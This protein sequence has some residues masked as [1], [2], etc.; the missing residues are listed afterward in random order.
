[1]NLTEI[2]FLFSHLGLWL[3]K[4]PSKIQHYEVTFSAKN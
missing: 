1:M 4:F 2:N 3:S